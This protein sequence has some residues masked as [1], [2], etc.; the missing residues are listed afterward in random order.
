MYN[1]IKNVIREILISEGFGFQIDYIDGYRVFYNPNIL[2]KGDEK[3]IFDRDRMYRI[4]EDSIFPNSHVGFFC[5]IM[6]S[7]AKKKKKVEI[8]NYDEA[9][10]YYLKTHLSKFIKKLFL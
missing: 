3:I 9:L 1:E 5:E 8:V 6:G 10:N 2:I 7:Y 4:G